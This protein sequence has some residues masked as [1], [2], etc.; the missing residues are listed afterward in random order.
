M[1]E[2]READVMVPVMYSNLPL[3]V[4]VTNPLPQTLKVTLRDKGINLYYYYRHRKDLT[5][6]VDVMT[7]YRKNDIGRIP[8][9]TFEAGLRNRLMSSTQLFRINPDT[10]LLYFAAKASKEVPVHLNSILSL[11]GQRIFSDTLRIYPSTVRL[12]APANVLAHIKQVETKQLVL[13]GLKDSLWTSVELSPIEGVR[14]SVSKVKVKLCV[15]EFTEQHFDL[16]VMGVHFPV[17]EELLAFPP[18]VKV[19]FFVG[20]SAYASVTPDQFEMGVEYA[21]L[22]Q[23]EKSK[24]PVVVVRAPANIQ[25]LRIQPES[26]ECLIEK[27]Q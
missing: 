21:H 9:S 11:G 13:R 20:L 19:T 15:E 10:I 4:S 12:F 3:D 26:V 22:L 25:N 27:K 1:Q 8:S 2:V 18:K 5:I 16:P 7:W 14:Y 24:Q 6:H 23:S 17:G